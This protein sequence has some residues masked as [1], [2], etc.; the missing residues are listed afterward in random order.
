VK[1]ALEY[2]YYQPD[3]EKANQDELENYQWKLLRDLIETTYDRNIF[4]RKKWNVSGFRNVHDIKSFSDFKNLPFT[5]RDELSETQ[6]NYPP[7]GENLTWPIERYTHWHRTSGTKGKPLVVLGTIDDWNSQART[8]CYN[9]S[10]VS[11]KPGDRIFIAFSFGPFQ[12]LWGVVTGAEM[13]GIMMIPGGGMHTIP[14]LQF[15]LQYKPT[16]IVCIPS[17]AIRLAETACENNIDLHQSSIRVLLHGGEPGASIPSVRSRIEDAWHAKSFDTTGVTEVGHFG[18]E[19]LNQSGVHVIESEF[20][21]EVFEPGTSNPVSDGKVGEL[22]LTALC[23]TGMPAIRYRTGDIV[24]M[25]REKCDCGR[26]FSRLIGGVKGR[27]DGMITVRG[28]NVY[29]STIEDCLM[30]FPEIAEFHVDIFDKLGMKEI[31]VK[32]EPHGLDPSGPEAIDL[33]EK[34]RQG[35]YQRLYLRADVVIVNPGSIPRPPGKAKRFT[36]HN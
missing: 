36:Y 4:Y 28:I 24:Q 17:Y 27:M 18:F 6:L 22:V 19:C 29:P 16:V 33:K 34:V 9:F 23:R 25:T 20:L 30:S 13:A 21:A 11:L 1:S 5:T 12:G 10:G 2:H 14:R 26:T 3:L 7:Y 32:I 15:I 8:W 35:L 31:E